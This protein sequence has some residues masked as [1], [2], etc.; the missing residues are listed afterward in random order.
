MSQMNQVA[1][2][3]T[4]PAQTKSWFARNKALAIAL[5]CLGVPLLACLFAGGVVTAANVAMRSSGAYQLALSR[6]EHDPSLLAALGAPL[7]PGW[8]TTGN[9]K[10][11]GPDGEA[12]L[13]IPISGRRGSGTLNVRASKSAGTWR[14]SQLQVDIAGRPTPVNLLA[15]P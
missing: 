15:A 3:G 6:A 14:F 12:S 8:L 10:V 13:A 9:V 1:T 7:Q 4:E 11:H 5:G 2:W